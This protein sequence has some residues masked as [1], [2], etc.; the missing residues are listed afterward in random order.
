MNYPD[1]VVVIP[2]A[3]V[4]KRM[5][6]QQPKQ[7]L[8][9]E[10]KAVLEHTISKFAD[11]PFVKKVV[12][13]VSAEDEYFA[14]M[15]ISNNKK[16]HRCTGGSERAESV[17]LGLEQAKQFNC[18]WVM[19]HD[20]ARPCVTS[21]D[22][23]SLLANCVTTNQ[24]GILAAPIADTVKQSNAAAAQ[25]NQTIDRQF[26]WRAFTPQCAKLTELHQALVA[27]QDVNGNISSA[28]TD[29]ASALELAGKPVNLVAGSTSNIKITVPEDLALAE[30]YLNQE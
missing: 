22:I 9:I 5:L 2:A 28:V 1:V 14:D 24:A 23:T 20:G 16:V 29:E 11:L 27:Q 7:Y 13:A 26:L 21:E 4:G 10:N 12:V 18:D 15:A 19:V 30:F 3:G 17:L 25:V 6:S 8:P